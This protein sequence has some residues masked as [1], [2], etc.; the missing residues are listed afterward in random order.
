MAPDSPP[1]PARRGSIRSLG[2][3]WAILMSSPAFASAQSAYRIVPPRASPPPRQAA[4]LHTHKRAGFA[5]GVTL[6]AIVLSLDEVLGTSCI[7]SGAYLTYCR[8][9]YVGGAV[10]AGG[11]GMLVGQMVKTDEP[12][13]RTTRVLVGTALGGGVAFLASIVA[14]EQEDDSNPDFLCGYDGMVSTGAVVGSAAAGGIVAWLIDDSRDGLQLTS[15]G[16]TLR[17]SGELGFGMGFSWY[18]P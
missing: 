12:P 16:P 15:L 18:H 9:G 5:A 2:M 3:A 17:A 7:G 10:V 11:L 14:C 8:G 4:E 6:S 1:M 13:G